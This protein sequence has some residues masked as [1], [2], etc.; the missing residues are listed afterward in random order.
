[1]GEAPQTNGWYAYDDNEA[2]S[3]YKVASAWSWYNNTEYNANNWLITPQ[4]PLQGTI[5]FWVRTHKDYPDSYAVL[6]STT[7]NAIE[8]FTV[9]LKP[10]AEG[11]TTGEWTEV[12]ID[13]SEYTG[14]LGYIAIHHVSNDKNYLFIDYAGLYVNEVPAGEWQTTTVTEPTVA[15]TGLTKGGLYEWQV[16]AVYDDDSTGDW[17]DAEL[18]MTAPGILRGDVNND[19]QVDATDIV[20]LVRYLN[21]G[22]MLRFF[23]IEAADA[24]NSGQVNKDDVDAITTIIMTPPQNE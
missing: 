23:N 16:Q 5:K 3:G 9:T 22:T 19:L 6:L 15:L 10:M 14:Q 17:T 24:D 18:F 11:P 7:G 8:D 21:D 20:Y 12:S 13:L 2:Y 4:I 1:M